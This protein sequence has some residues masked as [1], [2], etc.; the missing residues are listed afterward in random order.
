MDF[1]TLST[2]LWRE[3]ELL[4]LLLFKAEEKQYIMVTGKSEFLPMVA[5]SIEETLTRL[6]VLEVE[7]AAATE[8]LAAGLGIDPN[9]SLRA[10]ANAC[11]D[12]WR[13]LFSQHYEG[14]LSVVSQIR[15]LSDANRDLAEAGLAAIND[16]LQTNV[17]S[18]GTYSS[19]GRAVVDTHR[20]VTLD[21]TL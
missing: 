1:E 13:D 17:S 18:A 3:R 15:T 10:L 6:R 8:V 9:P 2:I 19:T 16:A 4:K 20:A 5:D 14:L 7:R 21:G 12:P 11:P